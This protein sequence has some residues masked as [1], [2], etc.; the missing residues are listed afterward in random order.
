MI[1]EYRG[2]VFPVPFNPDFRVTEE[3]TSTQID[4]LEEPALTAFIEAA[5]HC[6]KINSI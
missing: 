5:R 2:M 1:V 4:D 6:E 3:T